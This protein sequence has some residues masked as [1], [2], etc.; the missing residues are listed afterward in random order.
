MFCTVVAAVKSLSPLV[1][2]QDAAQI[3][4]DFAGFWRR[5][6]NDSQLRWV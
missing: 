4:R 1:V 6:T 5:L 3:F 2:G